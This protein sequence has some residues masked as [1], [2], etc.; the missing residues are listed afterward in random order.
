LSWQVLGSTDWRMSHR[1]APAALGER[2]Q[3]ECV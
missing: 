3:I 2:H 1:P